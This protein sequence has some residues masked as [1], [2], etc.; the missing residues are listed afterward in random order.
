MQIKKSQAKMLDSQNIKLS[1]NLQTAVYIHEEY[2]TMPQTIGQKIKGNFA[3]K[4]KS[5][6]FF[7]KI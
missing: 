3:I 7:C 6:E 2:A 4:M 5:L 1:R